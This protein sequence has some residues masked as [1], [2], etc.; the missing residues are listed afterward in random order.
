MPRNTTSSLF[1]PLWY[2]RQWYDTIV[3]L[4]NQFF[5]QPRPQT[6]SMNDD[7]HTKALFLTSAHLSGTASGSGC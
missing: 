4:N 6:V 3:S 7:I 1:A 5:F 2:L